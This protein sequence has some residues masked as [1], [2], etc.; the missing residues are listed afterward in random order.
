[1]KLGIRLLLA[2]LLASCFAGTA[3]AQKVPV[4]DFF[5]DAEF[6][7]V[8]LSP[9]GEYIAV[10]VPQEDR[11]ILVVLRVADMSV[12][13]SWEH[14]ANKHVESVRW[15]NDNRFFMYVTQKMGRYDFRVGSADVYASNID[16]SRRIEIPLGGTYEIVDVLP[17]DPDN[18]LVQRSVESAYLLRMDVANGRV[19][20]VANAPLRMGNFLVDHNGD[21]RY[22]FGVER[23]MDNVVLRRVGDSWAEVSRTAGVMSTGGMR[24]FGFDADN[25]LVFSLVGENGGPTKLYAIDP[26]T[27]ERTLLSGNDNVSVQRVLRSSDRRDV[28]AITY[29]DG[30]P[31]IDFVNGEHPEALTYAGLV[32]AFPDHDVSFHGISQDG[33]F[34][35]FNAYSDVDPGSYYLFDRETGQARFLLA[36]RSWIKPEQMSSMR[37]FTLEARDGTTLHGYITL[38][39]GSDGRNLPMILH[40][41]G[42]PFG[43]RDYWAFNPE[44]QFLASRG[45]AVLQVNFRGSGGYG[46]SF[47]EAGYQHYGTLLIDDMVDAVD[48]AIGEGI[49]DPARICT[50]GASYGG[51]AAMQSVARYPDRFSC[52]IGLAGLYDLDLWARDSDTSRSEFGRT[53][54]REILPADAGERRA[55]SPAHNAEKIKV[56]VMLAHGGR[57][58]RTPMSQYNALKRALQAAGNPPEVDIVEPREGH[59]FYDTDNQVR[60]FRAI[61]SFLDEHIGA[62]AA[63]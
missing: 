13:G 63:N 20:T 33:R 48:W 10:S 21:L 29:E 59:G 19:R 16:G 23:G 17:D 62:N 2:A 22:A 7:A 27:E 12:T 18:V 25:K 55:Q 53:G 51:F 15:V 30:L 34:V 52:A 26:D 4:E 31:G 36:A 47:V 32:N 49:A 3:L 45:Y 43:V 57:D 5:K 46:Q 44:A 58:Q 37:P 39:R 50:Y 24:P 28:L 41:H 60:L 42:G 11:T 6:S 35:L 9:T 61:E 14:G 54:Q 1:M 56:P 40:P 38:P 8:T